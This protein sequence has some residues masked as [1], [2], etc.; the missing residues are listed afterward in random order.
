MAL[1]YRQAACVNDPEW[2]LDAAR[3]CVAAKIANSRVVL[4]RY[5]RHRP[6][7]EAETEL[8]G[9][10]HALRGAEGADGPARPTRFPAP[11][12]KLVEPLPRHG[13][14]YTPSHFLSVRW[15]RQNRF[16]HGH[17]PQESSPMSTLYV[18][19]TPVL[20]DYGL[21]RFEGPLA[22]AEA[23]ALVAGDFVSA[24]GHEGAA[25]F[26]SARLGRPIPVN[27]VRVGLRPGDRAL[28][29]R[30]L[31]RLPEN[32]ILS[33]AEMAAL[34]FELGLLTRLE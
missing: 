25:A 31:E 16:R 23:R 29:L 26:L 3:R 32:R 18:I 33:E 13:R 9:M 21:W 15:A 22:E 1:H 20:T 12:R 4:E 2:A 5:L 11:A 17:L 8:A 24:L 27:R 19:N 7:A 30:L 6:E 10:R 14:R 34:P 28:V